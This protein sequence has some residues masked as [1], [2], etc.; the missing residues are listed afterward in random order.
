MFENK[1][2]NLKFKVWYAKRSQYFIVYL[3]LLTAT[4][5]SAELVLIPYQMDNT[6]T[7]SLFYTEHRSNPVLKYSFKALWT[8]LWLPAGK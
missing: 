7:S 4:I 3:C 1:D 2:K 6:H 8:F 5:D